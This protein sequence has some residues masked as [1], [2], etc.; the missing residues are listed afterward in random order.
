MFHT[1]RCV[2]ATGANL[3]NADWS[4]KRMYILFKILL[5]EEGKITRS[6]SSGCIV[7]VIQPRSCFSVTMTSRFDIVD[8]EWTRAKMETRRITQSGERT[9]PK[10]GRMKGT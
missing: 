8:E 3:L 7:T 6:R 2:A 4:M 9:F 10:N 1:V 5:C